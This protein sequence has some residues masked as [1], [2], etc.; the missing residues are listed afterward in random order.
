MLTLWTLR[1]SVPSKV[2]LKL[3]VRQKLEILMSKL[4][5][6]HTRRFYC[7]LFLL[8]NSMCVNKINRIF[9]NQTLK[10]QWII[11]VN[12]DL[13]EVLL[14]LFSLSNHVGNFRSC[15]LV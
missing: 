15:G 1:G 10:M 11:V 12:I 3:A 8:Q 2:K 4:T 5:K 14:P 6:S 13:C 9:K 7:K